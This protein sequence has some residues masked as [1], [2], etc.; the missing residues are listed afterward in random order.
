MT[1][2]SHDS[3]TLNPPQLRSQPVSQS[4]SQSVSVI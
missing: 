4:V 3:Q 1:T 2:E